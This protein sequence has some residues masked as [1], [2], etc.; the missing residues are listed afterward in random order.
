MLSLDPQTYRWLSQAAVA[1]VLLSFAVWIVVMEGRQHDRERG[2]FFAAHP[3]LRDAASIEVHSVVEAVVMWDV[4]REVFVARYPE[5][6]DLCGTGYTVDQA[7]KAL[8]KALYERATVGTLRCNM[9]VAT[10]R[11][12]EIYVADEV[13]GADAS[14][15]CASC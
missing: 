13:A 12:L 10:T 3:K 8:Q 4:E 2:E 1:L 7:C 14:G 15:A 11:R 6:S 5:V 9:K